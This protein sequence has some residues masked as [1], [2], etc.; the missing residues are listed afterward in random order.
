MAYRIELS[1]SAKDNYFSHAHRALMKK[2]AYL[3]PSN[4]KIREL[5]Q[6]VYKVKVIIN[7]D[8]FYQWTALEFENEQDYLVFVLKWA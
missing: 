3:N 4:K 7:E 8:Q 6:Q 1:Y 2:Y 5:W